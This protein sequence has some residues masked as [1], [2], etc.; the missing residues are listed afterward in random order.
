[1]TASI[2]SFSAT[3][4]ISGR[5]VMVLE[6]GR[7]GTCWNNGEPTLF[8][9]IFI[10]SFCSIYVAGEQAGCVSCDERGYLELGTQPTM[11]HLQNAE[12]GSM[13]WSGVALGSA[14]I[15]L[16]TVY[17]APVLQFDGDDAFN[18]VETL[19]NFLIAAQK[20]RMDPDSRN[21]EY[22]VPWGN[23]FW[24]KTPENQSYSPEPVSIGLSIKSIEV[25]GS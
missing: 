13:E 22:M 6:G 8:C 12:T 1:M 3:L 18:N 21:V 11:F 19:Y 10:G 17:G 9:F 24:R 23:G 16:S 2:V 14:L 25:P 20:V 15:N 4:D 7:I 5:P